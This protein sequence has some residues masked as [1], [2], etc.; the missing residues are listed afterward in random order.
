L[1]NAVYWQAMQPIRH[2]PIARL[3]A[4][5]F[6]TTGALITLFV[7]QPSGF[8][9]VPYSLL[10]LTALPA[11]FAI[12]ALIEASPRINAVTIFVFWS[13]VLLFHVL[14]P[15]TASGRLQRV[16]GG[17]VLILFLALMHFAIQVLPRRRR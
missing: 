14:N 15:G 4:C 1:I 10:Y 5:I 2:N 9:S 13:I 7:F 16:V 6:L 8:A 12:V 11:S 3:A 17:L